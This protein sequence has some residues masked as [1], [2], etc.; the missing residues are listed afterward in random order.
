MF[1][2]DQFE[3]IIMEK[4]NVKNKQDFKKNQVEFLAVRSQ[5]VTADKAQL[6]ALMN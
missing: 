2:K 5:S 6:G 4:E 1:K 3:N